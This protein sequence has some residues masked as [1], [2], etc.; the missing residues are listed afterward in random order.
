MLATRRELA[1][2]HHE[3][4]A[5]RRSYRCRGRMSGI[6]RTTQP[7]AMQRGRGGAELEMGSDGLRWKRSAVRCTRSA[8]ACGRA[9][10]SGARAEER[11]SSRA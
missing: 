7:Y 8:A 5:S 6:N 1:F 4:Q 11:R 2:E 3:D 10:S 9:C